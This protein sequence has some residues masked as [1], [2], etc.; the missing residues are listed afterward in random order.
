MCDLPGASHS[1]KVPLRGE[2][3]P[4]HAR[5][6]AQRL[7]AHALRPPP[8]P[9][10]PEPAP[11]GLAHAPGA[12]RGRAA[13]SNERSHSTDE[14]LRQLQ[15]AV[16]A[17][18]RALGCRQSVASVAAATVRLEGA[19]RKPERVWRRVLAAGPHVE[20]PASHQQPRLERPRRVHG[21]AS[22]RAGKR[23]AGTRERRL[24][25]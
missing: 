1:A 18:G 13:C 24:K 3:V 23:V 25:S 17:D 21:A 4:K 20:R 22:C 2:E 6:E 14:Q 19:P 8:P 10:E 12:R 16:S 5:H 7:D 11:H 9:R 15:S